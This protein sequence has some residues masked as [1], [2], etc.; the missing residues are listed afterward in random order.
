[1]S[2]RQERRRKER[3]AEGQPALDARIEARKKKDRENAERLLA[4]LGISAGG[5]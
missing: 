4:R 2:T 1:M 5:H 3:E